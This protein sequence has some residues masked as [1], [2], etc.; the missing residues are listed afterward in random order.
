MNT[1]QSISFFDTQF[2]KQVADNDYALNPFETMALPFVRGHVLDLGCGMGNLSVA[3]ARRGATVLAVDASAAA[4]ERVRATA[5]AEDL[6]IEGVLADMGVYE[7]TGRF[8]TIVSI[9]LLMFFRREKAL[10]L[11]AQIQNH[12]AG[13]GV[14]IVNVLTEGTT[15]ME[16]FEP[17]HHYL[18]GKHEL[19]DR[20]ADWSILHAS[21]DGFDAPGNT[22]KAFS[23]V[24]A[25]KIS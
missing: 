19:E 22:R 6:A 23:T 7:I 14:A 18:F 12:V 10:A 15:F 3:A 1:N 16:M 21:H 25:R 5:T 8:D 24:V 9:G 17:D 13:Q 20:F 4:I 2:K 11:L